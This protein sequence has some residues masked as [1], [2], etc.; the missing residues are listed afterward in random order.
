[1]KA[2]KRIIRTVL[3]YAV[4]IISVVYGLLAV[5][6][7]W[8]PLPV[9]ILLL[10]F[11]VGLTFLITKTIY[12][13]DTDDSR[14][15]KEKIKLSKLAP[16]WMEEAKT[17]GEPRGKFSARE[18]GM[19]GRDPEDLLKEAEDAPGEKP[20]APAQAPEPKNYAFRHPEVLKFYKD[21]TLPERNGFDYEPVLLRLVEEYL[22]MLDRLGDCPSVVESTERE[23]DNDLKRYDAAS[24]KSFWDILK[25]VSLLQ[26]STRVARIVEKSAT[27]P[28][29]TPVLVVAALGHD[30]GKIPTFRNDPRY[31][32]GSHPSVGMLVTKQETCFRELPD[33]VQEDIEH[34]IMN[35]HNKAGLNPV[36]PCTAL[37][38]DADRQAR[39]EEL[40]ENTAQ[41]ERHRD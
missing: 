21:V 29:T 9:F 20:T 4:F 23:Y 25:G 10:V 19:Q 32:V 6:D 7:H 24:G 41:A 15:G 11:S 8:G 37:I 36:P 39:K 22:D 33:S 14:E 27:L 18:R 5:M 26:H 12:S 30:I 16:I 40:M 38:Q 3:F 13:P 34:A 17:T 35:H 28:D 2:V 31:A 1:M